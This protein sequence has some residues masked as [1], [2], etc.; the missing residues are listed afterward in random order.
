MQGTA[1]YNNEVVHIID[2]IHIPGLNSSEVL[3]NYGGAIWVKAYELSNVVWHV[4]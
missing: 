1:Q 3:I 2:V 4:G